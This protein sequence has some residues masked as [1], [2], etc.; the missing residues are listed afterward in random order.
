MQGA[1]LVWSLIY[2]A[3]FQP[4]LPWFNLLQAF[5]SQPALNSP[6]NPSNTVLCINLKQPK[7]FTRIENSNN[8]T[9]IYCLQN[10]WDKSQ[11]DTW[12][13]LYLKLAR[14][15]DSFGYPKEEKSNLVWYG[16]CS[17]HPNRRIANLILMH[18][19]IFRF[20]MDFELIEGL[21]YWNAGTWRCV[22]P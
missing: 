11:H 13:S 4:Q 9:E 16:R 2:F 19:N 20:L 18:P 6:F 3:V 1:K 15:W 5:F 12:D 10:K 14:W 17:L 22:E 8:N 7:W 21:E